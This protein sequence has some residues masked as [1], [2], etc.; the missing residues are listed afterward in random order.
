[1]LTWTA[2]R[3]LPW[4][5][6]GLAV[7]LLG[8]T[9]SVTMHFRNDAK[10]RAELS[11]LKDSAQTVVMAVQAASGNDDVTWETAPG[12]IVALGDSNRRLKDSIAVQNASIDEMAREAIRLR[13]HA[14]EMQAIAAKAR[15]Q[16][17]SALARLSDMQASPGTR[18]DCL[19]LLAEAEAALDLAQEA[20]G[21]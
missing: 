14:S 21:K 16:R 18:A 4:R 11:D 7:C 13:K 8:I 15:A 6:I 19:Q 20:L 1:M 10:V 9:L 12:Q 17:A 2:I 3:A 5:W